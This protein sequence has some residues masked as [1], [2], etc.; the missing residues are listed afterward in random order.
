MMQSDALQF[1][2]QRCLYENDEIMV[3]HS[4]MKF[5]DGTSEAVMVV[6]HIKDGKIIRVETG[7]TPLK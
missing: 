1:H 2:D 3:E 7:A 6:N 4:V 5:P